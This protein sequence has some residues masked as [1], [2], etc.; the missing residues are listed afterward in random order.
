ML[1]YNDIRRW[2]LEMELSFPCF[3]VDVPL[4]PLIAESSLTE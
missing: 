1:L 3:A 2:Y 4:L